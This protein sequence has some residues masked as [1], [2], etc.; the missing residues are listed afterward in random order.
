MLFNDCI[1]RQDLEGLAGLMT[2]DH[3]FVD[4]DGKVHQPKEFMVEAWARFFTMWPR[5]RN[6]FTKVES[7]DDLVIIQ[8]HAFWS[9]EQPDDPAIWTATV[10]DDL[11]REWRVYA[12]T[13]SV[14]K[15]LG[16]T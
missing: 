5:Y 1:N 3:A 16:V 15:T 14:M 2:E 13:E 7:R 8:G 12:P 4:R 9:E 11:V 6:T 10:R